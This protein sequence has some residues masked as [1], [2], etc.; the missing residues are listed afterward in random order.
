MLP[1]QLLPQHQE[2]EEEAMAQQLVA[3]KSMDSNREDF[4][5]ILMVSEEETML[6]KM[7]QHD[8]KGWWTTGE[9]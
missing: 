5:Q 1:R 7:K 8:S 3:V 9:C 4:L 6:W 2:K